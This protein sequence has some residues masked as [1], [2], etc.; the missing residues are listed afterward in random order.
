MGSPTTLIGM[1]SPR[2]PMRMKPPR[3]LI[4]T[5]QTQC[6]S[7]FKAYKLPASSPYDNVRKAAGCL[8]S[9]ED[10]EP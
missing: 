2:T 7:E 5:I 3:T 9:G 6:Y 1:K 4:D 10:S 8:S